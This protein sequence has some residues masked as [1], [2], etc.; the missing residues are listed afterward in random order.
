MPTDAK[1]ICDSGQRSCINADWSPY[2]ISPISGK[3]SVLWY[4]LY[5]KPRYEKKVASRLQEMGFEVCVPTQ[6]ICRQWS[7]RRKKIEKVLFER[8]VFVATNQKRKHE[9]FLAGHIYRFVQSQG[10]AIALSPKEIELIQRLATCHE[11]VDISHAA[12][13]PGKE[14][15][16]IR[17]TLRGFRGTVIS[18]QGKSKVQLTLPGLGFFAQVEIDLVS[19][20]WLENKSPKSLLCS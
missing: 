8:Y 12:F 15:E 17:G 2:R 18:V 5:V 16:I 19:L 7:D 11:S 10:K 1:H 6:V 20:Q 4:A 3:D 14:V 13:T 9:V